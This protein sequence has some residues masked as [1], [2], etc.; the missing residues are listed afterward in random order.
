[1][2]QFTRN[3]ENVAS[4]G[5]KEKRLI[6]WLT[7]HKTRG[8]KQNIQESNTHDRIGVKHNRHCKT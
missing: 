3:W 8:E 6:A 5:K 7:E 2:L 4:E 1:M